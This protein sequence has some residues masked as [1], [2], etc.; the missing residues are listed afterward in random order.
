MGYEAS[1]EKGCQSSEWIKMWKEAI[2]AHFK[3]VTRYSLDRLGKPH[4][5]IK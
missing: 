3:L 5:L 4:L 1:K 2:V